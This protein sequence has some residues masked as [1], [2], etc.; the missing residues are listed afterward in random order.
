MSQPARKF[1]ILG[2]EE[3]TETPPPRTADEATQRNM[4]LLLLSLRVVSQRAL[5]AASH[6]FTLLLCGSALLIWWSVLTAP[7]VLQLVGVGMYAAFVLAIE[8]IRR[9][10]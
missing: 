10:R 1:Q 5:T 4:Q 7:T 3:I 8:W 9:T 2:E 6:L